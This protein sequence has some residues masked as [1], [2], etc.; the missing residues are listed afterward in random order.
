[1]VKKN[2]INED[3]YKVYIKERIKNFNKTIYFNIDKTWYF[4]VAYIRLH[5]K[6]DIT[7]LFSLSKNFKSDESKLAY[8]STAK[9]S[10]IF[11]T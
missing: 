7:A 3:D 8:G 5:L 11:Y 6:E 2:I 10:L 1:M 9:D 4:L